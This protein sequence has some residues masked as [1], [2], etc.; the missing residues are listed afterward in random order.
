MKLFVQWANSL[1]VPYYCGAIYLV[2]SIAAAGYAAAHERAEASAVL[3]GAEWPR[4]GEAITRQGCD[5][6]AVSH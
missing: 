3:H 4:P 6:A 1:T 2:S 5:S